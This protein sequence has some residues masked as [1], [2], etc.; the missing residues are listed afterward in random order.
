[1]E[2][3][4]YSVSTSAL[5]GGEWSPSH[6]SRFIPKE[7]APGIHWIKGWM[8][9]SSGLDILAKRSCL[10]LQQFGPLSKHYTDGAIL[11]CENK[12]K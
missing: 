10:P 5:G 6:P 7:K 11:A 4:F 12:R 8:N 2:V 9:L 3:N 1:V